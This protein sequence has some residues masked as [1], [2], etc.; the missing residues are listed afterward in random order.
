M[1]LSTPFWDNAFALS[2]AGSRHKFL[3][4][5]CTPDTFSDCLLRLVTS[6][7]SEP[8]PFGVLRLVVAV[9]N[10]DQF[11]GILEQ[12]AKGFPALLCRA[13]VVV[14]PPFSGQLQLSAWLVDHA[15]IADEASSNSPPAVLQWL[16]SASNEHV[17]SNAQVGSVFSRQFYDGLTFEHAQGHTPDDLL[18]AWIYIGNITQGRHDETPYQ[19]VNAARRDAF[20]EVGIGT[21]TVDSPFPA[22]T[23]IGTQGPSLTLGLLSCRTRPGMRLVALENRRQTSAFHYPKEESLIAPL[24]S[25]A[26]AILGGAQAMVFVSGTA[27]IVGAKSVHLGDI[28]QQTRQTIENIGNLLCARLLSDYDCYPAVSGLESIVSYTVYIKNRHD[29]ARVR[30]VCTSLLPDRAVASFVEADVCRTELLVEIEA[31]A[32]MPE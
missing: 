22:S 11:H 10:Q 8:A 17:P 12:L 16:F 21:G 13:E 27:S 14:Q 9:S 5:T 20:Q 31:I 18:R 1:T 7:S 15:A 25:R 24:F 26:V 2:F 32:V 4:A 19:Q 29:F 28:E 23:G 6:S 3:S 30:A